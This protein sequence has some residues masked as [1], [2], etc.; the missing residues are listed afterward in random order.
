MP[1][2]RAAVCM[3]WPQQS[4]DSSES[5]L[6]HCSR[7][8]SILNSSEQWVS[9]IMATVMLLRLL[10]C[11]MPTDLT[12]KKEK[13][14][15]LHKLVHRLPELNYIVFERLVFHLARYYLCNYYQ[16]LHK[17]N[18]IHLVLLYYFSR[19]FAQHEHINKMSPNNLAI[20]FAPCLLQSKE[21][22]N[23]EEILRDLQ[24]QTE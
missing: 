21:K 2:W 7:G 15:T 14:E 17:L 16:N 13:L 9:A 22:K 24:K 5:S 4:V 11:I 3:Q 6:S 1:L 12:S 10:A 19:R 23:P 18:L 20:I 8:T